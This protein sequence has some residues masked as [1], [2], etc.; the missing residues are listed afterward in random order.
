[1]AKKSKLLIIGLSTIVLAAGA[2]AAT[3]TFAWFTAASPS[4]EGRSGTATL[5]CLAPEQQYAITKITVKGDTTAGFTPS[6]VHQDSTDNVGNYEMTLTGNRPLT[7]VSGASSSNGNAP[8]TLFKPVFASN[9]TS[10]NVNDGYATIYDVSDQTTSFSSLAT[11]DAYPFVRFG[12]K[13]QNITGGSKGVYP[14]YQLTESSGMHI[15]RVSVCLM[16]VASANKGGTDFSSYA[17]STW[18]EKAYL[19]TE[20]ESIRP[21]A[22]ASSDPGYSFSA[23]G[24]GSLSVVGDTYETYLGASKTA[25]NAS[26][27]TA[28]PVS[29]IV[30]LDAKNGTNDYAFF[31]V[32]IWAEGQDPDAWEVGNVSDDIVFSMSIY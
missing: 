13:I 15:A 5:S 11:G 7:D 25:T 23:D 3:G 16:T 12:F 14:S 1:M 20:G 27:P 18:T 17:H 26:S 21:V 10:S 19:D 31:V 30:T 4:I 32:T 22:A 28:T 8:V 9:Y 24:A 6:Y 2:V 29:P